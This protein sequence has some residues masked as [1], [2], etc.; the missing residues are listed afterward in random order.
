MSQDKG[1]NDSGLMVKCPY[2]G[3]LTF[4]SGPELYDAMYL[5]NPT[6][7]FACFERFYV[8]ITCLK[9]DAQLRIGADEAGQN[10]DTQAIYHECGNCGVARFEH[11]GIIE[12]CPNCDDDEIDLSQLEQIP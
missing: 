1:M 9:R 8:K 6:K 3:S 7:C 12:K 5:N 11:G 10:V 2:C 4:V